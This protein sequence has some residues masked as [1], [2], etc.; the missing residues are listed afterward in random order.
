MRKNATL[1]LRNKFSKFRR[2]MLR[3]IMRGMIH[4]MHS[5]NR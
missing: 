5:R 2:A 3:G 1:M 4:A